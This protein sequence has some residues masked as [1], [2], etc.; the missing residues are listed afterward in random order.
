MV[1]YYEGMVA[2][3]KDEILGA[4]KDLKAHVEGKKDAV[5]TDNAP[6]PDAGTPAVRHSILSE[7]E[8]VLAKLV[9]LLE[10]K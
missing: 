2:N 4:I 7:I 3:V 10:G 9:Q 1:R 6:V 8:S 5:A